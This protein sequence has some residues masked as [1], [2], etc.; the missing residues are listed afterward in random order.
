[1]FVP[2][3]RAISCK[4][5]RIFRW[6]AIVVDPCTGAT[7]HMVCIKEGC[8]IHGRFGETFS[9]EQIESTML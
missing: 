6:V 3:E 7:R 8:K 5:E 2:L 9:H 4:W 1:M